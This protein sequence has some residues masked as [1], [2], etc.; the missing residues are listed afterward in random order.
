MGF[1]F[2]NA[3]AFLVYYGG[4][5]DIPSSLFEAARADGSNGWWNFTRIHL[6]LIT[7]QIKMLIVLTFIGSVQDFS[8]VFILTGGGPGVS[9]YVPGLE[10]YYNATRFRQ[11]GY[12]CALGLVMFIAILCGT[13][14]NMK[15]KANIGYND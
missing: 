12:A 2:I 3:F 7:P 9:T 13:I 6:P 15:M 11:Y 14:I 8:S 5:N 10:L 4:L 1:P